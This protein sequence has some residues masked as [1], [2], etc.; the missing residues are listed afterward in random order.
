MAGDLSQGQPLIVPCPSYFGDIAYPDSS[1]SDGHHKHHHS[2]HHSY[3]PVDESSMRDDHH[4][5]QS[6]ADHLCLFTILISALLIDSE[7][8]L[9]EPERLPK[10]ERYSDALTNPLVRLSY[11]QPPLRGP[12]IHQAS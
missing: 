7:R 2:H 3:S 11:R 1:A 5:Q 10:S 12:P 4:H 9:H 8:P 6:A